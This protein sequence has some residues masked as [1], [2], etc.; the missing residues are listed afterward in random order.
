MKIQVKCFASL[1]DNNTCDYS[2]ATPYTLETGST[3]GDLMVHAGIEKESV[4]L[5][6]VNGRV[7]SPDTRLSDGDRVGVSPAV[8]GM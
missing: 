7:A 8:G 1:A 5:I 6:F 3:A 2:S 4:K